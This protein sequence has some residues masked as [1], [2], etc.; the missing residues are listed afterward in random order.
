MDERLVLLQHDYGTYRNPRVYDVNVPR[1]TR[2]LWDR[3]APSPGT[4]A[5]GGQRQAPLRLQVPDEMDPAAVPC[6]THPPTPS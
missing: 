2:Y 3:L 4:L 1:I 5:P 6:L